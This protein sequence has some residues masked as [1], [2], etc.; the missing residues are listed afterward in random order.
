MKLICSGITWE[1]VFINIEA[2]LLS[3]KIWLNENNLF[4]NFDKSTILLHTLFENSL[5]IIDK[6]KIHEQRCI[7][8]KQCQC[9]SIRIVK[10]Y[11][12]LGIEMFHNI[13]WT[14]HIITITD[15]KVDIYYEII[16]WDT[17]LQR[18]KTIYLTL[19][20]PHT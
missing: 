7:I 9:K 4:W 11:K 2:A 14:N 17:R 5:P 8:L 19:V 10:N 18:H 20:E 3:V 13:K 15:N 12:Y 6:L 16:T 1:E